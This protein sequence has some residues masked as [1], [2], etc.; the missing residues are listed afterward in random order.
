MSSHNP[1]QYPSNPYSPQA[2]LGGAAPSKPAGGG[3]GGWKWLIILLG[4][5]GLGILGC[6]GLCGGVVYFSMTMIKEA[7]PYKM[8]M[9][10]VR[11][12]PDVNEKLGNPIEDS[13]NF[14]DG[15]MDYHDEGDEGNARLTINLKGPKGVGVATVNAKKT[16]GDWTIT[17]C[18]VRYPDGTMHEIVSSEG[19]HGDHDGHDHGEHDHDDSHDHDDHEP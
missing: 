10:K 14:S 18:T 9:A 6:C 17:E 3:G 16:G 11:E 19:D 8:A 2:T 4:L 5:G 1:P 7:P 13:I 12:N 15:G